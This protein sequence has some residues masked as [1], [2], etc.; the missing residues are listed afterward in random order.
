ML[1]LGTIIRGVRKSRKI[2]RDSF[3]SIACISSS[4]AYRAEKDKPKTEWDTYASLAQAL[5]LQ[6]DWKNKGIALPA[7]MTEEEVAAWAGESGKRTL[8]VSAEDYELLKARGANE[9]P[10]ISPEEVVHKFAQAFHNVTSRRRLG[11]RQDT[12]SPKGE[13]ESTLSTGG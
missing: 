10:A 4:T 3:A 13:P 8:M 1:S 12:R 2:P 5:G 9:S 7:D 11:P 6:I